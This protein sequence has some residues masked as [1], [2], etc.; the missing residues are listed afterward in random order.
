MIFLA[1]RIP[2]NPS[3]FFISGIY[4]LRETPSSTILYEICIIS[5]KL[6]ITRRDYVT[7][8]IASSFLRHLE[9]LIIINYDSYTIVT[10]IAG[11]SLSAAEKRAT[12]LG[13]KTNIVAFA[14]SGR[15]SRLPRTIL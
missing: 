7:I 15:R 6:I 11:L 14:D 10:I 5:L 4:T 1:R 9:K 12:V 13:D 8:A 3:T 2:L